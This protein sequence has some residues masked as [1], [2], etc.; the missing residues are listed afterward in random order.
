[1]KLP[2]RALSTPMGNYRYGI[3]VIRAIGMVPE[4]CAIEYDLTEP[5]PAPEAEADAAIDEGEPLDRE[6]DDEVR[7]SG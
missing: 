6:Q 7:R 4:S 3:D 2:R 5:E 1:M